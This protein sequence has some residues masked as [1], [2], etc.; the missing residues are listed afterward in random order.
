M[1]IEMATRPGSLLLI[2]SDSI[3]FDDHIERLEMFGEFQVKQ[4][5]TWQQASDH[6]E[7][8]EFDVVLIDYRV[9][10]TSGEAVCEI[11]RQY[12]PSI[13]IVV[14]ADSYAKSELVP[15]SNA[16]ANDYVTSADD[17]V[18]TAASMRAHRRA[19]LRDGK[20]RARVGGFW[21][22][23]DQKALMTCEGKVAMPRTDR[24]A[25]LLSYLARR[26]NK[27]V[28]TVLLRQELWGYQ[29]RVKTHT[30]QTHV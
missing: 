11:L 10:E 20:M 16:G 27:T 30:I 3:R 9:F 21:F 14:F 4:V 24:E 22:A 17:P 1:K 25:N 13:P 2:A 6:M 12:D 18:V 5:E 19:R 29:A 15:C 26:P 8:N 23:P 28:K 7:K